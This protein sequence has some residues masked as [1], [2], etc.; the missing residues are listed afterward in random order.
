M[1]TFI[2]IVLTIEIKMEDL[3]IRSTTLSLALLLSACVIPVQ[4]QIFLPEGITLE[5]AQA[6]PKS[7]YWDLHHVAVVPHNKGWAS[8]T[9]ALKLIFTGKA[10]QYFKVRKDMNN[11]PKEV[12]GDA[13]IELF[14]SKGAKDLAKIAG[15]IRNAY[16]P[17]K[18][19]VSIIADLKK[20][21]HDQYVASNIGPRA[22]P[23]LRNRITCD[24]KSP[25]FASLDKGMIVNYAN[26]P[27]STI[28]ISGNTYHLCSHYKPKDEY[29]ADLKN[30]FNAQDK[31]VGIFI[32]DS[33]NNVQAAVRKGFVGIFYDKDN[34][35]CATIWLKQD[36]Q[37][38]GFTLA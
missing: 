10:G 35:K 17:N 22:L 13:Y 33:L 14:E 38:L 12:S 23:I 6:A 25:L 1:L 21:G 15:S 3:M 5:S 26:L 36:L 18:E 34:K 16:K 24:Y 30:T 32:D 11:L 2:H 7:L 31:H 29:F 37:K 19:V 9:G 27:Q 20:Q 8:F 28:S 4:A